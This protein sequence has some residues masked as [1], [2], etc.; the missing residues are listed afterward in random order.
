[1]HLPISDGPEGRVLDRRPGGEAR[2]SGPS[3][4]GMLGYAPRLPFHRRTALRRC[5]IA[6]LIAAV[7]VQA[8]RWATPFWRRVVG[9]YWQRQCSTT[10][11]DA[12]VVAFDLGRSDLTASPATLAFAGFADAVT[13]GAPSYP[14]VFMRD[15]RTPDGRPRLV[16]VVATGFDQG[17]EHWVELTPRVFRHGGITAPPAEVW[18][19]AGE[20]YK[21]APDT[22]IYAGQPD[23]ADAS[24]FTMRAV[25]HGRAF[26]LDG[27]LRDDET[28][29]VEQRR[30]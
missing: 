10:T 4:N 6:F 30:P 29:V 9:L 27:W 21:C 13:A 25:D 2:P 11:A 8:Y 19:W 23:A 1:M 7:A 20:P 28:V 3:L 5:A 22:R 14:V 17:S 26:T 16:V 15:C 24:H 18:S 12:N